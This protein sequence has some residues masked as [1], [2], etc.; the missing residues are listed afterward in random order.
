MGHLKHKILDHVL[1]QKCFYNHLNY[2][3][4]LSIKIWTFKTHMLCS[5]AHMHKIVVCVMRAYLNSKCTRWSSSLISLIV[6][7]TSML[8]QPS[9]DD[10]N[11][12]AVV[13]KSA[14]TCWRR[15]WSPKSRMLFIS[16]WVSCISCNPF[17]LDIII[18]W[19]ITASIT[20]HIVNSNVSSSIFLHKTT[21]AL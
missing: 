18:P 12:I 17:S 5:R 9:D 6:D 2:I 7:P 11:L 15:Y 20:A 3:W 8:T 13:R 21:T 19:L 1:V 16:D 10:V 14:S 4:W